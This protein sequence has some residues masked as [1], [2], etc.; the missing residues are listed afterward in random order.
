MA[1][2]R[3]VWRYE[4]CDHEEELDVRCSLGADRGHV[5]NTVVVETENPPRCSIC[6]R[7][8]PIDED[9]ARNLAQAAA[10]RQ[11]PAP[12]SE[13]SQYRGVNAEILAVDQQTNSDAEEAAPALNGATVNGATANGASRHGAHRSLDMVHNVLGRGPAMDAVQPPL[14]SPVLGIEA[15]EGS[16]RETDGDWEQS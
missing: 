13:Q 15:E 3:R 4:D 1:C 14:G 9:V 6:N 5:H 12:G 16:Q 7:P 2:E 10:D 11:L 8:L